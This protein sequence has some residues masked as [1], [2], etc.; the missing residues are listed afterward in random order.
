[1]EIGVADKLHHIE[2][3]ISKLSELLLAKQT[4]SDNNTPE[5]TTSSSKVHSHSIREEPREIIEGGRPQFAAKL[6][7][8]EFPRFSGDDPTEWFTRVE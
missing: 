8:L 1:M 5:T 7:N 2:G 6:A 3:V 4:T